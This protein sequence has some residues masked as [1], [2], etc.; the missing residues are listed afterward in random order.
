[1]GRAP[2]RRP[3]PLAA[4][5]RRLRRAMPGFDRTT[6]AE[7][8]DHD[9]PFQLLCSCIISLR[10]RDAVTAAASARLFAVATTPVALAALDEATIARAIFPAGFYRTKARQLGEIARRLLTEHAGA[11]PRTLPSLLSLPGVGLKTANL[12]LGL[13]HGIPAICVDVHVHRIA[14][15]WGLVHTR[16][17]DESEAALRAIVPRRNWIE[18]NDLL[19]TWGQNVCLPRTPRCSRCAISDACGRVGVTKSA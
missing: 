15:R 8:S 2:T 5:L 11:V 1:M 18:L 7:V 13:G 14:N 4:V 17:P 19:V 6:L 16:S 12:V 3:F 10:T 9:D